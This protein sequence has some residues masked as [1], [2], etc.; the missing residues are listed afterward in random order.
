MNWRRGTIRIAA[1]AAALMALEAQAINLEVTDEAALKVLHLA[2]VETGYTCPR[3]ALAF[4][5]GEMP[6]G[7]L[8]K[9]FCGPADRA[10][11]YPNLAYRIIY[12]NDQRFIVIPWQ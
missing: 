3:V 1:V 6:Q 9:V 10:G 4:A 7:G 2:I 11:A 8:F 5:K 12:T